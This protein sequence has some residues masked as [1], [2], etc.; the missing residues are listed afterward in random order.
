[1][2][3]DRPEDDPRPNQPDD[4]DGPDDDDGE[5]CDC[6]ACQ[7]EAESPQDLIGAALMLIRNQVRPFG[8]VAPS[9]GNDDV[10]DLLPDSFREDLGRA[11]ASAARFLGRTFDGA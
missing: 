8:S 5:S 10:G 6:P 2:R 1:M 4:F 7:D 3:D 11:L 9:I